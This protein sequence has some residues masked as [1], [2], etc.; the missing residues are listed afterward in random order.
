MLYGGQLIGVLSVNE[1]G[2]SERKYSEV[3]AHLLSLFAEY[4]ASAVHA[5]RLLQETQRRLTELKALYENGLAVGRLLRANE[6]GN[7]VINTFARYLQWHHVTI[8]LKREESDDLDLVAFNMPGLKD[9]ERSA[10]EQH[11]VALINKVGQGFSGWVIQTGIPFRTGNVH[12]H[13]QY[14][15]THPGIQSGLYMPLKAGERVIGVISVESETPDAFTEQDERLLATLAN[16]AAIAFENARLYEAIQRELSERKRAEEALRLSETHYRE[17]ADSITDI[18]FELDQD[19][20]YTHWNKASE[21]FSGIPAADVI[22]KSIQDVF[23]ASE[24]QFNRVD[25]YKSVLNERRARTFETEIVSKGQKR[26]LEINAYPSA[27]GASVVAKDI[28][29]RKRTE[30]IMQKR[31][32]LMEYSADHFLDDL[33]QKTTDEVSDLTDSSFGFFHFM[34]EDQNT[35]GLQIWSTHALQQFQVPVS[36]GTHLPL[37]QAGVW[38]EAA[39]QRRPLIQ[40]D[41]GS[42]PNEG[43]CQKVICPLHVSWSFRLFGTNALWRLWELPTNRR[44]TPNTTLRLPHVL[45]IMPGILSNANKWNWRSKPNGIG[46]HSAWTNGQPT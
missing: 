8:R 1:L 24:A 10:T 37:D 5:A 15:D 43:A 12:N 35:L 42:L 36:Q 32:E 34:E 26:A 41:Y 19:L 9:E 29:D 2:E 38:A 16:Q 4:A 20:R 22:G 7:R 23:G 17:L 18:L 21:I 25:I 14:V 33:M 3:D 6:I 39:R 46:W 11:F 27:R 13:P 44:I 45:Q 30:I 28:T 40:N 31:F